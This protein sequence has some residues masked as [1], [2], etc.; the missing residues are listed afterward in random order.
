MV[1]K[2]MDYKQKRALVDVAQAYWARTEERFAK[3]A[4][5]RVLDEGYGYLMG[6]CTLCDSDTEEKLGKAWTEFMN[7]YHNRRKEAMK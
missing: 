5:E 4:P 3:T 7:G 1:N 2:K 6:L